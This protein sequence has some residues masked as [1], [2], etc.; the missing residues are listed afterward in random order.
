MSSDERDVGEDRSFNSIRPFWRHP[1]ITDWLQNIDS[2]GNGSANTTTQY[3]VKRQKSSKVDGESR[4][5]RGL[6][7]NFYDVGYL[8]T[9]D[10]SQY[11]DLDP[12]P[13]VSLEFS[14]SVRR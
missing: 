9:L 3:Q 5:V 8:N 2:I 14:D 6:P 1:L 12:K 13:A 4:V 11:L 7:V 10:K